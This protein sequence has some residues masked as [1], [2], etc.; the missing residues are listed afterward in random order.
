M[1]ERTPAARIDL[2]CDCGES[3]G[4]WQMGDDAAVL[5]HV[6]S[7]SIA[8]GF[9]AGDAATM[10][11]TV[12]LCLAHG[13]AIGAHPGL[14]DLAGFGRRELVVSAAELHA[15]TLYQL[16]ALD[17][18]CRSR[19]ARL[20]H[21]KPHGAL[22]HMLARQ[23][24]LA[25]AFATAVA[26]FNPQLVVMT[27]AT[28]ALRAAAAALD[29]HSVVEGFAERGYGPDGGLLARSQPGAELATP[30]L[31]LAQSLDLTVRGGVSSGDGRWWAI[32][33][34][35]LCLH[36]DRP[37]AAAFAQFLRAGLEAAGVTISAA[38]LRD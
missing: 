19:G 33:V 7:A 9:H 31:A 38:A 30:A 2:N 8:C 27:T 35:T 18:L 12:E 13:V 1:A 25:A 36:G 37:D 11:R 32:P 17:G 16:G 28:G 34:R 4:A 5:P 3:F 20:Q 15:E 29:L 23:P 6:S 26:Q 10:L 22:Y 24:A 14:R 21:V